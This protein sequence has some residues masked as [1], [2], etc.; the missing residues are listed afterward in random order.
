MT[1]STQYI[2]L[3]GE[4]AAW[5]GLGDE[6]SMEPT[7]GLFATLDN[8]YLSKDGTEI[9]RA[10]GWR[11]GGEPFYGQE[12]SITAH[13]NGTL[14]LSTPMSEAWLRAGPN[15]L[16]VYISGNGTITTGF[17]R[18]SRAAANQ[19]TVEGTWTG[20]STTG[21][22]LIQRAS[23]VHA[24]RYV[25]NRVVGVCETATWHDTGTVSGSNV[26][27]AVSSGPLSFSDPPVAGL[28]AASGED[29]FIFWPSPTLT[30][31]TDTERADNGSRWS[32]A[33]QHFTIYRRI[34]ADSS[35]R[36]VS[37]AVPGRGILYSVDLGK[38]PPWQPVNEDVDAAL[39]NH[40]WTRALGV[41]KGSM[42]RLAVGL[43]AGGGSLTASKWYGVA[44]GY[45][46]PFT[47]EVGLP[48]S[49]LPIYTTEGS[50]DYDS[51]YIYA[52]P[53]RGVCADAVGLGIIL[54]A[55]EAYDTAA[56]A[57]VAP[58]LP[59]ETSGPFSTAEDK[60]LVDIATPGS[61]PWE[62]KAL[63]FAEPPS[64]S[65]WNLLPGR[66]PVLELMPLGGSWVTTVRGRVCSGGLY[67]ETW[68]FPATY[69]QI[70]NG[71]MNGLVAGTDTRARY[72][73]T[74]LNDLFTPSEI[75][76]GPDTHGAI[77]DA[78]SG[79]KVQVDSFTA[80]GNGRGTLLGRVVNETGSGSQ[81]HSTWEFDGRIASAT[82]NA[83][84]D[85][86]MQLPSSMWGFT[87]EGFKSVAPA[88]NRIVMDGLTN[89]RVVA[90]ARFGDSAL[91]M[92]LR[93]TFL[94][95]WNTAPRQSSH[96]VLSTRYGC[97]AAGSV[98]EGPF[99]TAWLSLEGPVVFGGDGIRWIG[100]KIREF[101]KTVQ[102]SSTGEVSNCTATVDL[103]RGV[104][105]W[106]VRVADWE[107]ST[108]IAKSKER[109]DTLLVW[110]YV[111]NEF[112]TITPNEH[113]EPEAVGM[114][115]H[116][117][118]TL[119]M[120]WS[121]DA[122]GNNVK[123]PIYSW[124]EDSSAG[125]ETPTSLVVTADRGSTA[126]IVVS[127][128]YTSFVAGTKAF[129]RA[130][131]RKTLRWFG[132]IASVTFGGGNTTFTVTTTDGVD[133]GANWQAGDTVVL[134]VVPMR[135]RT[136]RI[137]FGSTFDQNLKG[138]TV[139]ARVRASFAYARVMG[140]NENGETFYFTERF[141]DRLND[142]VTRFV[143]GRA[144][145]DEMILDVEVWADGRVDIKDIGLEVF[146]A[147]R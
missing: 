1:D 132:T 98:A 4:S 74:T 59:V 95:S 36:S 79:V 28:R 93:E 57:R 115:P 84:T 58:L 118:G 110:N 39:P 99:G 89:F 62:Y 14:T 38:A 131:D 71:V 142:G 113:F 66:F 48:S 133:H 94:F 121:S 106:A 101:W 136:N 88:I 100:Q 25:G 65:F 53:P 111:S 67:P 49:V 125:V 17:Y 119:R 12:Y 85:F 9:R 37:I 64:K 34:Q 21:K 8:C 104:V 147:E 87:E 13:T 80:L 91:V 22:V 31:L 15:L 146:S 92:T 109:A 52:V 129:V 86:V 124:D 128:D 134:G 33:A 140:E 120:S 116:D 41:P 46:D 3:K 127:G 138:I 7:T 44:I 96:M 45:W 51:F 50:D 63:T 139:R 143:R 123:F 6:S 16:Q 90:G 126:D 56:E 137:R 32:R 10:P 29:G 97:A 5:R 55:T 145:G 72:F 130:R 82:S 81:S 76:E 24:L 75:V 77:P 108:D 69:H 2:S 35:H 30:G 61:H 68:T 122:D 42:S 20:T 54:Y 19:I 117:D 43:T 11:K 112:S 78:L 70:E 60:L 135:L 102:R 141:G 26:S 18:A 23:R 103:E 47:G 105:V 73:L 27:A 144:R 107:G 40:R 114:L 83:R